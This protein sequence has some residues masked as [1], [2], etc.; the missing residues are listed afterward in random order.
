MTR[1]IRFKVSDDVPL[2]EYSVDFIQGMLDR[3]SMS[4]FRYGYVA[5]GFPLHVDAIDSMTKRL[6]KYRETRNTEWLV[7]CANFMMIEWM[8]PSLDGAHFAP[9]D[10]ADSPGRAV[11]HGRP[12]DTNRD[13]TG[14]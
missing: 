9:T 10:S 14:H 2:S 8:H 12:L 3:M 11:T 5:D 4:Y 1:E 6:K 7:D 13:L